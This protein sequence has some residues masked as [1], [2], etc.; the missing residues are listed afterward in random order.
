MLRDQTAS[1][2][3]AAFADRVEPRLRRAL[4]A[5]FG[6]DVG[7]DATAEALVYGWQHWD[8]VQGMRNPSGYLF[9]VGQSA[10]RRLAKPRRAPVPSVDVMYDDPWFEP[11]LGPAWLSL[12][13]RQRTVAGLVHGYGWS[14]AEVADLLGVS[15]SAVQIHEGRAMKRLRRDLGVQP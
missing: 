7:R 12:S 8:R 2:A 3:Y 4:T 5:A 13:E 14:F 9:R 10:G 1:D 6:M 15:K 11:G